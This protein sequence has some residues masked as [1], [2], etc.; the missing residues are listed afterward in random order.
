MADL[1]KA[2]NRAPLACQ[3]KIRM[4]RARLVNIR[5]S[6]TRPVP[7]EQ[8]SPPFSTPVSGFASPADSTRKEPLTLRTSRSVGHCVRTQAYAKPGYNPR[9][10]RCACTSDRQGQLFS[11]CS[12]DLSGCLSPGNQCAKDSNRV[13]RRIPLMRRAVCT[14]NKEASRSVTL[15]ALADA[16]P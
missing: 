2:L 6:D 4:D 13:Q 10:R 15:E 1:L 8:T 12:Q 3:R 7:S 16:S 11:D 14:R 5:A 9:S